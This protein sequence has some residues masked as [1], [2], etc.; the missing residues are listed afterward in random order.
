MLKNM[1]PNNICN[2][3]IIYSAFLYITFFTYNE[4]S[5]FYILK[6]VSPWDF[7]QIAC[8]FCV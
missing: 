2:I 3:N 7:L 5:S 6:D 1:L 8:T 4:L